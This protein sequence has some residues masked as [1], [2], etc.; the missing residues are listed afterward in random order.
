MPLGWAMALRTGGDCMKFRPGDRVLVLGLARSGE[1]AARLL[2]RHGAR[3]VVNDGRQR[4]PE[5]PVA[6]AL[7]AQGAE[8]VFGGH[9]LSLLDPR[10]AFIVKNPGIPY[11]VP[12]LQEAR[13]REIPI[14]TEIEVGSWFTGAPIFAVTGSNGKTTT[15]TLVGEMLAEAG[16]EPIVAGNIGRV[17]SGLVEDIRPDQPVVL[18]VSSFQLLGTETFH[19]R[20]AV[21]LN[22]Y[23]AHLDYH[24]TFEAYAAAKW[25]LFRNMGPD[26]VAVLNYDQAH[27]REAAGQVRAHT[28][29]FSRR[30][31]V[32]EGTFVQDGQLVLRKS[33][34]DI[35]LLP[36]SAVALRGEHNLEN[37]LAAAALA[38]WAGAPAKAVID[39]LTR[40][41]GIEHR[42][43]FVRT[44]EGVDY[45]N[46][47]KAT[48]PEAALRALRA[49]PGR[50]VW[51]A[52][53]LD[54]GDDFSVL[55]PELRQRVR[56]AVL[57]GQSADRLAKVCEEAGVPSVWRCAR[58][59]EAVRT[60]TRLAEAGDTVLLSPAC[61]S[62]DMFASFEERGRMFKDAVHTL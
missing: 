12:L 21:L 24:E 10:P 1:A 29:W 37:A 55:V 25:R 43:E 50:I 26:D 27:I 60:A 54:R 8:V 51:I 6:D 41:R 48:N 5:E 58:L 11:S 62:W 18:E 32:P 56:A 7:A 49:C 23:P 34:S 30:G 59:D 39:V 57:I 22:L 20:G 52:G 45:Y 46:D 38:S 2:M 28:V 35:P 40:F 3:V 36:V 44:V 47:S 53:G 15:T 31:E 9:P 13:R 17:F 42:L 4:E 19:P 61:A 16:M 33:G 14:Y